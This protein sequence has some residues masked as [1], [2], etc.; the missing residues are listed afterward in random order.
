MRISKKSNIAEKCKRGDPL[1]F[2]TIQFVAKY[3]K[4]VGDSLE[5]LRKKPHNAKKIER[6]DPLV[7]F[8]FECY[9]K[10]EN[11]KGDLLH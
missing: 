6:A 11:M 2:F 1:G 4:N 8:G 5:T 3:Q 10:K 7:S 9:V